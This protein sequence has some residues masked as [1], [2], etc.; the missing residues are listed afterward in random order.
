MRQRNSGQTGS[1]ER[2]NSLGLCPPPSRVREPQGPEPTVLSRVGRDT[3]VGPS[4]DLRFY[5]S[6]EDLLPLSDDFPRYPS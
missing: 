5:G 6:P 1:E 2:R 3:V 4:R